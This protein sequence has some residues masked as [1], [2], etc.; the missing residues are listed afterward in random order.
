MSMS[1]SYPF[2]FDWSNYTDQKILEEVLS[3]TDL[4]KLDRDDLVSLTRDLA[5]RLAR[6]SA[7]IDL[8]RAPPCV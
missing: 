3:T 1:R 7:R 8:K 4:F 5:Q 2:V 6:A